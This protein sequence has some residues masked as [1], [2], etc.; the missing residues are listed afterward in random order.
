MEKA[1]ILIRSTGKIW[2]LLFIMIRTVM[3]IPWTFDLF[4]LQSIHKPLWK[5]HRL[6]VLKSLYP[7]RDYSYSHISVSSWISE[8]LKETVI[9]SVD[10]SRWK[11][12]ICQELGLQGST[13]YRCLARGWNIQ[14]SVSEMVE[15]HSNLGCSIS[16]FDPKN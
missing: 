16:D 13:K 6:S 12:N 8:K 5:N 9:F 3:G 10:N 7:V 14:V 11:H 1:M 4:Q 2:R 15:S